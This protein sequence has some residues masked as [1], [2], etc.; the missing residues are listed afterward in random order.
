MDGLVPALILIIVALAVIF[1]AVF[2]SFVP[3]GVWFQAH[4]C[5]FPIKLIDLIGMKFRKINPKPIVEAA[6]KLKLAGIT[7][8]LMDLEAHVLAG[9]DI[10]KV[11]NGMIAAQR[12]GMKPD[13]KYITALDLSGNDPYEVIMEYT[14]PKELEENNLSFLN[15]NAERYEVS[16][17]TTVRRAIENPHSY[18]LSAVVKYIKKQI[19]EEI[20][21]TDSKSIDIESL[22]NKIKNDSVNA[23]AIDI[24]DLKI[25]I[26]EPLRF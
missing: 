6:I 26:K 21:N 11:A 3:V 20:Y 18:G 22:I 12:S 17:K 4:S 16:F 15:K 9:G 25:Y 8:N 24:L 2:L 7:I 14:K 10:G 1:L 19:E 5:G 23:T 13:F